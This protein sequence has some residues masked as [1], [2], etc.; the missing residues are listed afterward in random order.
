MPFCGLKATAIHF[1]RYAT[2]SRSG[3]KLTPYRCRE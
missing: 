3:L 2:E 1:S